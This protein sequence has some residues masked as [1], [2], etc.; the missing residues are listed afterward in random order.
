MARER[1]LRS[2]IRRLT[3][4]AAAAAS[5]VLLL[6]GCLFIPDPVGE[7]PSYVRDVGGKH[8]K[9]PI[10][11]G[12]TT[13]DEVIAHFSGPAV[14]PQ[15]VPPNK[16]L[17]YSWTEPAGTWIGTCYPGWPT[18]PPE[19]D[20]TRVA[21]FYF[22]ERGVLRAHRVQSNDEETEQVPL[23]HDAPPTRAPPATSPSTSDA[24]VDQFW[25]TKQSR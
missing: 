21:A 6:G 17:Y 16:P 23:Q 19:R 14:T 3:P 18:R 25:N 2:L 10:R 11:V 12:V 24:D 15:A 22:D 8:S 7:R 9:K 13:R 4:C 1:R 20:R 5:L